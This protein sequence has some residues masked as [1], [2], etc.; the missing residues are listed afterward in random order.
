MKIAD[1]PPSFDMTKLEA[2]IPDHTSI[3]ASVMDFH[4]NDND[5]GD[6]FTEYGI[7]DNDWFYLDFEK[8]EYYRVYIKCNKLSYLC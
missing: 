2:T 3:D 1:S 4:F 7:E 6:W 5:T 8:G